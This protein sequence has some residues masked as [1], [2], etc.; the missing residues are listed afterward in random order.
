[1]VLCP[2]EKKGTVISLVAREMHLTNTDFHI[3]LG[4]GPQPPH[5]VGIRAF[6]AHNLFHR[7]RSPFPRILDPALHL[8]ITISITQ[9]KHY[10]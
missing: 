7:L 2:P 9:I 10:T 4:E 3:F 8:K 5:P 1:M 6:A